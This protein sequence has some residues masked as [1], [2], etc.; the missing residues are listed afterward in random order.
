MMRSREFLMPSCI[1]STKLAPRRNV[2]VL[3]E[4]LVALLRENV[5]DLARN[6]GH[7]APTAQEEVV[8][9]TGTAWHRGVPRAQQQWSR[10]TVWGVK[11]AGRH[12]SL[13]LPPTRSR[14]VHS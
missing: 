9:F 6:G 8:T 13:F 7:R 5:G 11:D 10:R 12:G 3:D 4:D 1:A 2:V 14:R